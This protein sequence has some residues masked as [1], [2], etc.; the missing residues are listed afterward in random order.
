MGNRT[1]VADIT[2]ADMGE[3]S[4]LM[5]LSTDHFYLSSKYE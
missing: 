3:I 5:Y 2:E 4:S 1:L